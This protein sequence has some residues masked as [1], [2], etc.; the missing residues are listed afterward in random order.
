MPIVFPTFAGDDTVVARLRDVFGNV[1]NEAGDNTSCVNAL[2]IGLSHIV[3]TCNNPP[4]KIDALSR[5]NM[6]VGEY[7][8]K[9]DNLTAQLVDEAVKESAL[10]YKYQLALSQKDLK[11]QIELTNVYSET[12][13]ALKGIS[14]VEYKFDKQWQGLI[15]LAEGLDADSSG[16][17]NY[18]AKVKA[19][20]RDW[21][22]Q[23]DVAHFTSSDISILYRDLELYLDF[24]QNLYIALSE[25]KSP[26]TRELDNHVLTKLNSNI[27]LCEE[28]RSQLIQSMSWRLNAASSYGSISFDDHYLFRNELISDA[29]DGHPL[30]SNSYF[31]QKRI[32]KSTLTAGIYSEF[33]TAIR[34]YGTDNQIRNLAKLKWNNTAESNVAIPVS[35]VVNLHFIPE[36][37][38]ESGLIPSTED[39]LGLNRI[40]YAYFRDNETVSLLNEATLQLDGIAVHL[41]GEQDEDFSLRNFSTSHEFQ[42]ALRF[43]DLITLERESIASYNFYRLLTWFLGFF[44]FLKDYQIN[45]MLSLWSETLD[46][47]ESK[48]SE[49]LAVLSE[50]ISRNIVAALDKNL[51][52][53]TITLDRNILS[54]VLKLLKAY[55][56]QE[57]YH[58]F[59]N[60]IHPIS[61]YR[62]L[63]FYKAPEEGSI[64][65][66][67]D[68]AL[69]SVYEKFVE[70]YCTPDVIEAVSII[71]NIIKQ[72]KYPDTKEKLHI[73]LNKISI[74]FIG[75]DEPLRVAKDFMREELAKKYVVYSNICNK[76]AQGFLRLV[77]PRLASGRDD[78]LANHNVVKEAMLSY[79]LDRGKTS[80]LNIYSRHAKHTSGLAYNGFLAHI[81]SLAALQN[82]SLK[83]LTNKAMQYV[84]YYKGD[85]TVYAELIAAI[86]LKSTEGERL[87]VEY[88]Q[89]RFTYLFSHIEDYNSYDK[90]F[91]DM[92]KNKPCFIASVKDAILTNYYGDE[93]EIYDVLLLIDNNEIT[94]AFLIRRIKYLIENNLS[95][96]E[97]SSHDL[98]S[99]Y[100]IHL[101]VPEIRGA[102]LN[103]IEESFNG[104]S[105]KLLS[106]LLSF[107]EEAEQI[108]L[109][110]IY[111]KRLSLIV[112]GSESLT[113]YDLD[114]IDAIKAEPGLMPIWA[115][116]L[117]EHYSGV[118]NEDLTKI[119]LQSESPELSYVY[120][121]KRLG[122]MLKHNSLALD[123]DDFKLFSS[124]MEFSEFVDDADAMLSSRLDKLISDSDYDTLYSKAFMNLLERYAKDETKEKYRLIRFSN[125]LEMNNYN[126]SK[127]YIQCLK[128][129]YGIES[130]DLSGLFKTREG[131]DGIEEITRSHAEFLDSTTTWQG[132]TQFLFEMLD[133]DLHFDA[134][135]YMHTLWYRNYVKNPKA[136]NHDAPLSAVDKE[137]SGT[138]LVLFY[139]PGQN[140]CVIEPS[141]IF[142]GN[143]PFGNEN[144]LIII[145]YIED[146]LQNSGL[147]E[148]SFSLHFI[149]LVLSSAT[150]RS[151]PKIAEYATQLSL[152]SSGRKF[153]K[154]VTSLGFDEEAVDSITDLSSAMAGE[155]RTYADMQ[156]YGGRESSLAAVR[157]EKMNHIIHDL[158]KHIFRVFVN[159]SIENYN[160]ISLS[161]TGASNKG[162]RQVMYRDVIEKLFDGERLVK[163]QQFIRE[164]E[165]FARVYAN[166]HEKL[167]NKQWMQLDLIPDNAV[168]LSRYLESEQKLHLI[169]KLSDVYA[170]VYGEDSSIGDAIDFFGKILLGK[171]PVRKST[172]DR[173]MSDYQES[174]ANFEEHARALPTEIIEL[175]EDGEDISSTRL[176]TGPKRRQFQ[177][178]FTRNVKDEDISTMSE[179]LSY[180]LN[181]VG[182]TDLSDIK[183]VLK[184]WIAKAKLLDLI[185]PRTTSSLP[186]RVQATTNLRACFELLEKVNDEDLSYVT[187]NL[188]EIVCAVMFARAFSVR[189]EK[190]V[191]V[192]VLE[193]ILILF[194]QQAARVDP[195][196]MSTPDLRSSDSTISFVQT[197]ANLISV[198][199]SAKQ[200]EEVRD[201]LMSISRGYAYRVSRESGDFVEEIYSR[202]THRS[203]RSEFLSS[204]LKPQTIANFKRKAVSKSIQ[205][206][207]NKLHDFVCN[208]NFHIFGVT[209]KKLEFIAHFNT[210]VGQYIGFDG[211]SRENLGK[212]PITISDTKACLTDCYTDAGSKA[213]KDSSA[214]K[215]HVAAYVFAQTKKDLDI[216]LERF[217][218]TTA[219]GAGAGSRADVIDELKEFFEYRFHTSLLEG[220]KELK[221]SC[222]SSKIFLKLFEERLAMADL[223]FYSTSISGGDP[224]EALARYAVEMEDRERG[225]HGEGLTPSVVKRASA[226]QIKPK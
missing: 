99:G 195:D 205:S 130:S 51:Y 93:T 57:S 191:L 65:G 85:N 224:L 97:F 122:F 123:R 134:K 206:Y 223:Y 222:G 210:L 165:D 17:N 153:K 152:T 39:I 24:S 162:Y 43:N 190:E 167:R 20:K 188:N 86:G 100:G 63:N 42:A 182:R 84:A 88:T 104:K 185:S 211:I 201:V 60:A 214:K 79:V 31:N 98:T 13:I 70:E 4:S 8:S 74:L 29:L 82:D 175:L 52:T 145:D 26:A 125:L 226:S 33:C 50:Y 35:S 34:K 116:Y 213:P 75:E 102:I 160:M 91:I 81:N 200:Q 66:E 164:S 198:C 10:A 203:R 141:R 156:S 209:E 184:E 178:L 45:S 49:D 124:A 23:R 78:V 115:A 7:Q 174:R 55:G 186:V 27:E 169:S 69:L 53:M 177:V 25:A 142:S 168:L 137:Y 73:A 114:F 71:T 149:Q 189:A 11:E 19:I 92:C 170:E 126:L 107:N 28:L 158:D 208:Y 157:L 87:I 180:F 14:A 221:K 105:F 194:N 148:D 96:D 6:L 192:S 36:S 59:I 3:E 215:L 159:S 155:L 16:A 151:N 21:L 171:E 147:A 30:L 61:L 212:T 176:F 120:A 90:K 44:P 106:L 128:E 110:R 41:R 193:K 132:N 173:A 218:Q 118:A 54:K 47:L 133:D 68:Y 62:K 40:N 18:T 138:N 89:K 113:R 199:G 216:W 119:V 217:K 154:M 101:M 163:Y 181:S 140:S 166:L 58:N 46:R 121:G 183:S 109:A 37:I 83:R 2:N 117:N 150:F 48:Y 204:V 131:L 22:R 144:L 129:I 143:S 196:K 9:K 127:E 76:E 135:S 187:D 72:E 219:D 220:L 111:N 67:L 225:E 161:D 139:K 1:T 38:L 15:E 197:I 202:R 5:Y 146:F 94:T 112:D 12:K 108:K 103:S 32:R 64:T 207:L 95:T 172:A 56:S 136:F 179:S 77:S 80:E